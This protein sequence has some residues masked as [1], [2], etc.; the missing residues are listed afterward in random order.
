AFFYSVGR[1]V[2]T[3]LQRGDGKSER[4]LTARTD[5][6]PIKKNPHGAGNPP[7]LQGSGS[8]NGERRL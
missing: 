3:R 8:G 1:C 4:R 7:E 6:R 2:E 5:G